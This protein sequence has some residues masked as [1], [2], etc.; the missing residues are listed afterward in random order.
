MSKPTRTNPDPKTV[1]DSPGRGDLLIKAYDEYS[2][3]CGYPVDFTTFRDGFLRGMV[4]I[5][6]EVP[7][8]YSC[9]KEKSDE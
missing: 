7:G 3:G 8:V 9:V 2:S 1:L 6:V 5:Q 4:A